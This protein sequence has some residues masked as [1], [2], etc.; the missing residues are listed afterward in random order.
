VTTH[1]GTPIALRDG[2]TVWTGD[3]EFA[4]E[5]EEQR[6][7]REAERVAE[8][9]E[10][11]ARIGP[12]FERMDDIAENWRDRVIP[13]VVPDMVFYGGVTLVSGSPKS[14]KSTLV[15]DMVRAREHRDSWLG[16]NVAGGTTILLTEEGGFPVVSRWQASPDLVVMQHHVAAAHHRCDVENQ[17][18][19]EPFIEWVERQLREAIDDT[20]GHPLVV[21]DTLAVWSG[22]DDENDASE[23][24]R[25]VVRWTELASRTGAAVIIVHHSR[26][27]GGQFGESIRGSTAILAT[28][29]MSMELSQ[30]GTETDDRRLDIRGRLT[31]GD[32]LRLAF[33][34][35]TGQYSLSME[36]EGPSR[37]ELHEQ[38]AELPKSMA[39]SSKGV[40][41]TEA[42]NVW[43]CARNTAIARLKA[44]EEA[45]LVRRGEPRPVSGS[46]AATWQAV[47]VL[48][49][50][51]HDPAE[52]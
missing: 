48:P 2:R 19:P 1:Q 30:I 23:T 9:E 34:R 10:E 21:I 36:G 13:W 12:L 52:E 6:T 44:L 37:Q 31:F 46:V 49:P 8:R 38:L 43:G 18:D 4:L 3:P 42:A 47:A 25:A 39:Y 7:A 14:G 22:I 15:A 20:K 40:T 29:A 27:G 26:K 32:R 35:E 17:P 28:V 5:V 50:G 33:D 11:R 41:A 16:R 24:T 51:F 45:G